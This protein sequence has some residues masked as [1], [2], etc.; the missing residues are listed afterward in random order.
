MIA[1]YKYFKSDYEENKDGF[2]LH[3]D[4][5]TVELMLHL[6]SKLPFVHFKAHLAALVPSLCG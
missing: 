3:T 1:A 4:R 6:T 2:Y 5:F